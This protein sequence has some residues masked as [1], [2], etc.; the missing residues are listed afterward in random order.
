VS[1]KSDIFS[2]GIIFYELLTGEK[3]FRGETAVEVMQSI[4][5]GQPEIPPGVRPELRSILKRML[6]KDPAARP[7]AEELRSFFKTSSKF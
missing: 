2:T 5:T 3:P 7:D 1:D 4:L 6:S